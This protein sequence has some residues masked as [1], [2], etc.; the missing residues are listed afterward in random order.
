[1][2]TD[3][4]DNQAYL[5]CHILLSTFYNALQ[6]PLSIQ[7]NHNSPPHHTKSTGSSLC[8][9]RWTS[10]NSPIVKCLLA[11]LI[12]FSLAVKAVYQGVDSVAHKQVLRATGESDIYTNL[13]LHNH[14]QQWVKALLH[15]MKSY[16]W[17]TAV[18]SVV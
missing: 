18:I 11:S 14:S 5:L 2:E 4:L 9:H 10:P 6:Q 16:L 8:M 7:F 17:L 1:M 15:T 13:Q 3:L 12:Q